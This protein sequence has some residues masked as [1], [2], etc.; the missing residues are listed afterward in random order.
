MTNLVSLLLTLII[1]L[2]T[3]CVAA[4]T[5]ERGA[6][7]A[8]T[9]TGVEFTKATCASKSMF[10]PYARHGSKPAKG[11][12][13]TFCDAYRSKTCCD[14]KQTNEVRTRVVHMQMNG[15]SEQCRDAWSGV[16]CAAACDARVGVSEGA[17]MC[18]RAC[19]AL[20]AAC[21]ED[22]FAEDASQRLVPCRP[23][24]TICTQ[25]KEWVGAGKGKGAEACR[26]AGYDVVARGS[27]AWCFDG[28]MI[29]S[30]SSS[31]SSSWSSSSSSTKKDSKTTSSS[32]PKG[33]KSSKMGS[34][35]L[36]SKAMKRKAHAGVVVVGAACLVYLT[37]TRFIPQ[38]LKH[39]HRRNSVNSKYAARRAAEARAS[40]A[41]YL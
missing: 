1:A 36:K 40:K 25:L 20:Y 39:W 33:K 22:F 6:R 18:E 10:A 41:H 38:A 21:R 30:S 7:G 3:R 15:F 24:D 9:N 16:E 34:K 17:P 13:L 26:A 29:S 4:T 5:D 27:D 19:D 8:V 31:S 32:K 35:F 37:A 11:K 14:S 23:S 28:S 12:G 2:S